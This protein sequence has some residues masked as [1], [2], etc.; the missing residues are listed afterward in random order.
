MVTAFSCKILHKLK[1]KSLFVLFGG[2]GGD[3][4]GAVVTHLPPT[5]EVSSSNRGPYM[6]MLVVAYRWTAVYSTEP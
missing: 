6:R 1:T 3:H 5:S 2:V 4:G